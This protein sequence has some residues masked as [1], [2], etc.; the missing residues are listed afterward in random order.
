MMEGRNAMSKKYQYK[1]IIAHTSKN[2]TNSSGEHT[3]LFHESTE[4]IGG[5]NEILCWRL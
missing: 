2:K 3:F 5:K 4:Y 1:Q